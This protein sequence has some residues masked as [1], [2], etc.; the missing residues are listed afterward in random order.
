MR[1]HVADVQPQQ[2]LLDQKESVSPRILIAFSNV[3][4]AHISR[5]HFSP[6][7]ISTGIR[8]GR[9][10]SITRPLISSA[11]A[12]QQHLVAGDGFVE[13]F[14]PN[15]NE[16]WTLHTGGQVFR[17]VSVSSRG[18]FVACFPSIDRL[19]A[20]PSCVQTKTTLPKSI[21]RSCNVR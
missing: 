21:V 18:V 2:F 15:G 8:F 9:G 11:L 10:K 13:Q 19:C 6:R 7:L 5:T 14:D 16:V 3:T 4:I 12:V 20:S 17:A 1:H